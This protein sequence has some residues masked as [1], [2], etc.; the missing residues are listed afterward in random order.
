MISY[1]NLKLI[2]IIDFN[3]L[4][5]KEGGNKKFILRNVPQL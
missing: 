5:Y 2:F 1:E 3:A 4:M